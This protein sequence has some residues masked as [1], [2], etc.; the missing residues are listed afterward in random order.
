LDE[1][2]CAD[3]EFVWLDFVVFIG[4]DF[5]EGCVDVLVSQWQT[6]VEFLEELL[7][8]V[9]QLLDVE[10]SVFIGVEFLEVVVNMLLEGGF[11][12]SEFSE[13]GNC[14]S[15]FSFLEVAGLD[16]FLFWI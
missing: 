6:D 3:E 4:V 7:N 2:P 13:L 12:V 1:A 9:S 10:I 11:V 8:K 5:S 16:H 14:G 15:K